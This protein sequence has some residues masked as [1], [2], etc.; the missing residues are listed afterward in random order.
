MNLFKMETE[1]S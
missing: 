1:L